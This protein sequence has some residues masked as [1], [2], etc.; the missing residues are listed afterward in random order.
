MISEFPQPPRLPH[1]VRITEQTWPEG[2]VPVVSIR[3]ITY[4]HVNFIRD[5]I[6][7]FLMQETAFPVE[8]LI[9][10]DAST[11]GT[12]DIVREYQAKYPKLIRTVLQTENQ[13]SKGREAWR[14]ARRP[15]EEMVRGEF[16]AL[17]EGD[18]YWISPRK[19]QR[20]VDLMLGT[21]EA[22]LCGARSLVCEEPC[23]TPYRIEP[24]LPGSY[25]R[26]LQPRDYLAGRM[27]LR[28]PTRI[29]R[30][31][32]LL[33]FMAWSAGKSL[34]TGDWSMLMFFAWAV[35]DKPNGIL[36]I[37]EPLAVYR[38]HAGGVWT[39]AH[40]SKQALAS[41]QDIDCLMPL[42]GTAGRPYLTRLRSDYYVQLACT[43]SLV[44]PKRFEYCCR[45]LMLRPAD[46][47]L[48]KSLLATLKAWVLA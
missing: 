25:I 21:P 42:L 9:H 45:A 37:D 44:P 40:K 31:Q 16:I 22:V 35:A 23:A 19:L 6:E 13:W 38:E 15:F 33:D 48:W 28:V 11:D 24:D 47:R 41:L 10:D 27:F 1:P 30:R 20:Q 32:T 12:A 46:P 17:C 7:G 14:Q 39:G 36:F 43:P 18:D 8:I 29:L 3:C 5:A 4:Q 2:T 26:T 34:G